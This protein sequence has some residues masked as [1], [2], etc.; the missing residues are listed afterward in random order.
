MADIINLFE[1]LGASA[2]LHCL[3]REEKITLIQQTIG[4]VGSGNDTQAAIEHIISA[5]QNLVCGI[6]P[7]K[8]PDEEQPD[9]PE[10]EPQ[11]PENRL[12][13]NS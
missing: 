11:Q 13:V 4:S 12:V 9:E 5:R 8:D 6:F 3:S 10:D 2:D 7:A 1:Q